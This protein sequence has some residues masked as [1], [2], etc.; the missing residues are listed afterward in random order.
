VVPLHTPFM[1]YRQR[2]SIFVLVLHSSVLTA[3]LYLESKLSRVVNNTLTVGAYID[4]STDA[5][6]VNDSKNKSVTVTVSIV[7][8]ETTR[9]AWQSLACSPLGT[10]V[11]SSNV[12]VKQN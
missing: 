12:Y 6:A 7:T 2:V 10:A 11:T 5:A 4:C 3:S 9:N 1:S 8:I